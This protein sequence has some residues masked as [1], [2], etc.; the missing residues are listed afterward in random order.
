MGVKIVTDSGSDISKEVA[1]ALDITVVPLYVQFGQKTYRDGVDI[2][3]DEFFT[4]LE[5]G[6]IVPTT[7][8]ASPGDFASTYNRLCRDGD[9]V[10]SIH[11]SSRVSATYEAARKGRDMLEDKCRIEV[12]DSR[13]VSVGLSLVTIAA[14]RAAQAGQNMQEIVETCSRIIPAIKLMGLL[15]TLK[16]VAR[17]GRLGKVGPILSSVL[18]IKPLLT[19]KDGVLSPVGV[20]RT[21][22]KG[23]ERLYDMVKSAVNIKDI[24]IAHSSMETEIKS[25][26]ERLKTLAPGITPMISKLGPALGAHGGPGSI[27]M[28]VQ[29]EI[30]Q[31]MDA[32]A[33]LRKPIVNLPSLQSIKETL[34]QRMQRDTKSFEYA[35]GRAL[36]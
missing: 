32:E 5:G 2:T 31:D 16:Y 6:S 13:Y 22:S 19:M 12:V 35:L 15:D 23:I 3:P 4:M 24:T 33:K 29:Q 8:A 1:Q 11:L 7:S 26:V 17:G 18:P 34:A 28:A 36:V 14:A 21:R 30:T 25:V 27:L 20:V 9:N 10:V